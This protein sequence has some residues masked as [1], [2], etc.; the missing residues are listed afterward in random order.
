MKVKDIMAVGAVTIAGGDSVASAA[1]LMRDQKVGMLVVG[2]GQELQGL[3]TDRDLLIRCVSEGHRPAECKV[4]G[5]MSSPVVTMDAEA[6]VLDAAQ[7]LREKCIKRLPVMEGGILAGVLSLT[8]VA[9]AFDRPLH[10]VLFGT[11]RLRQAPASVYVGRVDHYYS[12]LGVGGLA[13]VAAIHRG[14]RAR[15]VGHTTNLAFA[16]DSL[17]IDHRQ[18]EA[19]YPGDEVALKVPGRVR[20]GDAV[21]IEKG[22]S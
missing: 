17:E 18:V 3:V 9:Q 6:D 20:H 8:D 12:H 5:H 14:D 19:A 11:G 7:V 21:Y 1:R 16:V 2:D 4:S 10:D 15:I 22:Q 13:L